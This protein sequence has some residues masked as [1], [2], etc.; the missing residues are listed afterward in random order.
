MVGRPFPHADQVVA[1]RGRYTELSD[2]I[3]DQ[4]EPV[5][6][7]A[8]WEAVTGPPRTADR[9]ERDQRRPPRPEAPTVGN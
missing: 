4:Q 6:P 1:A 9:I 5:I 8:V 3:A 7:E 2:C